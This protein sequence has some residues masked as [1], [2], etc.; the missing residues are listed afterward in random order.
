MSL[1]N[2]HVE[3]GFHWLVSV[4][5]RYPL[6]QK[7]KKRNHGGNPGPQI[8]KAPKEADV[9]CNC[10]SRA[11]FTDGHKRSFSLP[12]VMGDLNFKLKIVRV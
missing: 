10:N 6:A 2:V 8:L 3:A 12:Y 7:G 11:K 4:G 1:K 9:S 5:T